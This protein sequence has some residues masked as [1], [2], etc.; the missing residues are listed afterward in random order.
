LTARSAA[1]SGRNYTLE[2]VA[3]SLPCADF[4]LLSSLKRSPEYAS[5]RRR[6]AD[7]KPVDAWQ[8]DMIHYFLFQLKPEEGASGVEP[9]YALFTMRWEDD[10]PVS[11]R[12]IS[13]DGSGKEVKVFDLRDG[14]TS[15]MTI[16]KT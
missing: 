11:A 8:M 6:V 2:E 4:G 15:T 13:T 12:V 1:F 3:D 7:V 9:P 16:P 5:I 10:G 14:R